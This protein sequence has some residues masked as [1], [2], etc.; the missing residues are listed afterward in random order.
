VPVEQIVATG[1]NLDIKNPHQVSAEALDP[2]H[3]LASY[4]SL[5]ADVAEAREALRRELA[6]SLER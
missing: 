5:L 3:L 6:A 4:K 2:E 1:Y